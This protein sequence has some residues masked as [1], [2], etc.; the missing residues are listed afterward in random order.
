[1][2]SV[3]D[4]D[5]IHLG[6]DVHKKTI[7]VGILESVEETARTDKIASDPDA[8]VH[9]V[10]RFDDRSRLRACYEAGP[11]GY[12]LCR[13]L[14]AMGVACEVIAPALIPS[15][16]GDRVKTD[17]RDA[18]RLARLH[19][20]GELVAI[21]VPT[22]AE[23]AVRDLCRA[24]ADM[25]IDLGRAQ[26]RL[27]K[28]L[29]RHGRVWVGGSNWTLKHQQWIASQRFEEPA[30]AATLEHYRA[31][32]SARQAAV[33][34]IEKDLSV[35]FTRAPFVEAVTRLSAYRGIT[36]LGALILASE[37][38]DWRRFSSASAFMAFCGLVPSEYSSGGR[39]RRG[40]ITHAGNE[41]VRTQLVESAWAYQHRALLSKT[42]R[43]RQ[44][45]LGP[46]VC[47]RA[48][49]A[50]QRLC[51]RFRRL[52]QRITSRNVVVTAIARELAGFVWA[53]MTQPDIASHHTSS[54]AG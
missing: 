34:A 46:Q 19:R 29:L 50:Q 12:G 26:H 38:C 25:V 49:K 48:W 43:A 33:E 1:M 9:L 31:T 21:R 13:Q 8:V 23:E 51:G 30:A 52:D 53:E 35:W 27:D 22:E 54:A 24:R 4:E 39:T 18:S 36:E 20:A 5:V 6:L 47:A 32:L 3:H 41:H 40:H 17:K 2:S 14:R 11:T 10:E 44:Q 16:P 7:S 45:G 28:F 37:V 15:A 42:I